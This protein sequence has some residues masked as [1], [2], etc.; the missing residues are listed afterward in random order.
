MISLQGIAA[1]PGFAVGRAHLYGERPG[2]VPPG[3][4]AHPEAE[5]ERFRVATR[6]AREDL[7]RLISQ[8]RGLLGE[9]AASLFEAHLM[10]LEDPS[11]H[12]AILKEIEGGRRSEAAVADSVDGFAAR[13]EELESPLFR[14]RGSDIREVGDRLIRAL[15]SSPPRRSREFPDSSILVARDLALSDLVRVDREQV[16]GWCTEEGSTASHAAILARALGFP[17]VVGVGE[18]LRQAK[19]GDEIG[20]DG[21]RGSVFVHPDIK[22]LRRLE[23]R[24]ATYLTA[25]DRSRSE[26]QDPAITRD[27]HQMP[28]LANLPDS[29]S[30]RIALSFGAE[31]VGLLRTE[32]LFLDKSLIPDEEE[33]YSAYS[34]VVEAMA[35]RPVTVRTLDLGGDKWPPF[36]PR[37]QPGSPATL[38]GIGRSL[39]QPA[40]F[41]LQLRALLRAASARNLRILLPMVTTLDE[42]RRTKALLQEC[43]DELEA[44]GLLIGDSAQL[45]VMIEVPAAVDMAERLA[46]EADFLSLGTN[47]L[48]PDLLSSQR[49]RLYRYDPVDPLILHTLDRVIEAGHSAGIPVALC[50]EL[51][52]DLEAIPLLVGLGLDELSMRPTAIPEAKARVRSLDQQQAQLLVKKALRLSSA[53]E[54]RTLAGESLSG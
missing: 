6:A 45:G 43:R 4:P 9:S 40:F 22:T 47:D 44:E 5:R 48:I 28:I 31:G 16:I 33:Q 21:E 53:A 7:T 41:K 54:I 20:L 38:R 49:S 25:Q 15:L 37:L 50:G 26:A 52:A 18:A 46:A 12:E 29:G 3:R 23:K 39:E 2:K 10:M 1:S 11:F 30:A 17:A 24:Q 19:D 51:A 42:V 27:G 14:A 34:S 36:L 35:N 32:F 8:A 13:L